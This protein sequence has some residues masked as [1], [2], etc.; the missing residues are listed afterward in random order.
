MVGILKSLSEVMKAI[1]AD[2]PEGVKVILDFIWKARWFLLVGWVV[3]MVVQ[4]VPYLLMV[5]AIKSTFGFLSF[6][7]L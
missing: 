3:W 6:L 4:V 7:F 5:W 2:I 1:T